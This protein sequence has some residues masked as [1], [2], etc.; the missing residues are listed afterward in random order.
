VI[1]TDIKEIAITRMK[2]LFGNDNKRV[3]HAFKSFKISEEI[4]RGEKIVGEMAETV[5]LTAVLHD[6]GIHEAEKKITQ[7]QEC[8][9]K[10]KGLL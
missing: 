8:I 6:I 5:V 7:T 2:R 9:K 10:L 4:M 3:N 1:H